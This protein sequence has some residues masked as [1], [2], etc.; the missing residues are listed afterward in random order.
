MKQIL[1]YGGGI[2]SVAMCVLVCQRKLPRPDHIVFADT[3][4][5]VASTHLYRDMVMLPYLR[6][7]GLRVEIAPH[8][9]SSVDLYAHNGDLLLPAH[10]RTGTLSSFCS[11]EWKRNVVQRYLRQ[12]YGYTARHIVMWIG[13]S[14]DELRRIK[15][16]D[17]RIYPLA[18]LVLRRADCVRIV[19]SA[20]L[21][22]PRKSRC[23]C[24][25]H[26]DTGEWAELSD[27]ECEQAIAIDDAI[28][29]EDIANGNTGVYL[30]RSRKPL[31]DALLANNDTPGEQPRPCQSG[32][33]FL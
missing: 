19:Q 33:C 8:S 16:H 26:Q 24:C 29:R 4:R 7:H 28:H 1:S 10:T 27:E 12:E 11:G 15:G 6:T 5:E 13:F 30:H 2:Q 25:P 9:L 31:R 23:W 22:V 14:Y 17:G 20:G 18:A 32:M 3:G 21:P